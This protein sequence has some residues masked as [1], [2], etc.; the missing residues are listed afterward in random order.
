M[1]AGTS[2]FRRFT[3]T[4]VYGTGSVKIW[5]TATEYPW[6]YG[7]LLR[8][9]ADESL[10]ERDLNKLQHVLYRRQK[11]AVLYGTS[12]GNSFLDCV[13]QICLMVSLSS[14]SN[15]FISGTK[16]ANDAH[17]NVINIDYAAN[18]KHHHK[19][20]G[21]HGKN[22][23]IFTDVLWRVPYFNGTE[24]RDHIAIIIIIIIQHLY[25]AIVS[26]AGCRGA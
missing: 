14:A 8:C 26:Y 2:L 5:K 10:S 11:P 19:A 21:L 15:L 1:W 17:Q 6:M 16:H 20:S 23:R 4:N 12:S 18:S 3:D 25:S 24:E 7:Y 9:K 22:I 13:G